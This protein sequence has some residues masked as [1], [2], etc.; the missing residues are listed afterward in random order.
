MNTAL[1][2]QKFTWVWKC[3]KEF[4]NNDTSVTS[5]ISVAAEDSKMQH[6]KLQLPVIKITS[7]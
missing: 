3:L 2:Q 5:L 7:T 1:L 4:T 6:W